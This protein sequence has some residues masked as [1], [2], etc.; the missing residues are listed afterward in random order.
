MTMTEALI[1]LRTALASTRYPLSLPGSK[2]AAH[3][4]EA[5]ARQLDDYLIPRL[6]KLDAPLLV[7]AGGSTGAGKSTL[8]NSVVGR[9]VSLAGARRP[10]TRAPV[11]VC[12]PDDAGWFNEANLLPRI[13]RGDDFRVE[14]VP[15]LVPGL[16][17]LDAPDIDSV[18]ESNRALA[19]Q[20]LAAADLW[21]FVTTAVRYADAVPWELLAQARDRGTTVAIALNRV[22]PG[23]EDEVAPHLVEMLAEHGLSTTRMFVIPELAEPSMGPEKLLP[24]NVIVGIKDWLEALARSA[25]ARSVVVRQTVEGALTAL[26]PTTARLAVEADAQADTLKT[27]AASVDSAYREASSEVAVGVEDGAL[28]RGEVLARWQ[29]LAGTGEFMRGLQKRVGRLRDRVVSA[30]TGKPLPDEE[31]KSALES[32]LVT[33]VHGTAADAAE[34]AGKAWRAHP[35]GVALVTPELTQASPGIEERIDRTVRDWQR[36]VLELVRSE[37]TQKLAVAKASAYAVNG[38]GLCLMVV[39]FTATA[40]IP[41]GAEIAVGAG[42][43]IAAQKVLEAIFGDD[44]VRRLAS[45]ARKDLLSRV[46]SLLEAEAARFHKV[47]KESGVD[48][49]AGQRLRAAAAAVRAKMGGGSDRLGAS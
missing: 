20:L 11:L 39:V 41:T 35:A 38:L 42:T 25:S 29:E 8:V 49:G 26:G 37:S 15:E 28:F 23:A 13:S 1:G 43:T 16:A 22:P 21:L 12:H 5:T 24:P 34:R 6:S 33:F 46:D 3:L 36:G 18:E 4:A 48:L 2:D 14:P 44:A 45:Y 31:L 47:L 30:F 40:F 32:G 19:E 9:T 10:T 27:L 17:L 7:V